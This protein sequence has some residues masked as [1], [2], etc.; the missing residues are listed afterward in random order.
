MNKE[1]WFPYFFGAIVG[2]IWGWILR[3]VWYN[4]KKFTKLQNQESNHSPMKSEEVGVSDK[5][6]LDCTTSNVLSSSGDA[7]LQEG[8]KK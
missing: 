8:I 7:L 1:F 5:Q 4:E 2:L 3:S 6:N